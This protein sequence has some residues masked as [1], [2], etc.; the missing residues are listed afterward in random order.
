MKLL[1][2]IGLVTILSFFII[3]PL[4]AQKLLKRIS[5]KA[6]EKVEQKI[7]K[8]A[9]KKIDEKID[10][11]LDKVEES[12]E[13]KDEE[14]KED[15]TIEESSKDSR[16]TKMQNRMQGILKSAGITGELVP[17]E[18]NYSFDH[19]IQMHIESFDNSGKNTSTGEF[20][21]HLN[22]NSKNM[23]YE[24]VSGDVAKPGQGMFIIDADNGAMIMLS[25]EN[26]E[27]KG[28]IYGMGAYME[29]MGATYDEDL[30][31]S[32]TP[33]TY[34]AN[35]N[36]KK[37]GK[38]KTIA[39]Y[40][41]EEYLYNDEQSESEIWITKDMKLNSQDFFSTI[42]KTSMYSHGMGWGY[43]M[44]ATSVDKTTGEKSLMKVTKVDKNSN[45]KFSLGNYQI[46]N[47]G[48]INI[49]TE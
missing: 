40:K 4:S 16:E 49:P 27:K 7:E 47:L 29:M 33:E 39:G 6:K 36:V 21:I 44:E 25:N 23:A 19:L 26:G 32:E 10:T 5:D 42:F 20:I 37:T 1:Y 8:R 17:Y 3:Q 2:K 24:V 34:L 11:E 22:P 38:T 41:C 14:N 13:K 18:E 12:L 30:D 48:N 15:E 28:I 46:T 43:M 45:T 35:P 9:E 31:L